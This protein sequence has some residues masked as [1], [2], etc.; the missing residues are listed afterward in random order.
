MYV[1]MCK[2]Q[3]CVSN[4]DS[5]VVAVCKSIAALTPRDT[6]F[7]SFSPLNITLYLQPRSLFGRGSSVEMKTTK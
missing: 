5:V 4:S 6:T 2:T 7:F 1:L 3:K